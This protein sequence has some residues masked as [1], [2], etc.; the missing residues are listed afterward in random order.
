MKKISV[1][2]LLFILATGIFLVTNTRPVV[3]VSG[4]EWRPGNIIDDAIFTNKNAMSISQIQ[5]FLNRNLSTCDTNGTAPASDKGRPDL[6]HAQYAAQVGWPGPPYVCLNNYYE[7]PK[8]SPSPEQPANNFSGSI[9]P[10]SKSAAELIWN[11]S[12]TYNINPQVLLVKLHTES[13]GPLTLDKWPLYSQ[14][15]YAMG[16]HCPDSGPGGSANCDPNYSGFSIQILES[17]ALLRY[18]IN[19][20]S[21]PWWSYKKPL[22][23]NSIL[24]NIVESNC[25]ASNVYIQNYATAALYTY[26]PYQPNKPALDNLYGTGDGCS[27][28]GNR[29]FWRVFNDWFGT[30]NV[31]RYASPLYKTAN[32]D[33]IYAVVDG[34]KYPL[35]SFEIISALGLKSYPVAIVDNSMLSQYPTGATVSSTLAKKAYDPNGTIYLLDDGKRYPVSIESCRSYPDG[36][37]NSSTTWAL[38]CFNS[39]VVSSL[40]NQLIDY[41]SVEDIRLHSVILSNN[42]AWKVENGKKRRITDSIF[43][44]VLG[45]WGKV[46][47]MFQNSS[48][49]EGKL[50]IPT[51]SIVKFTG[52][53]TIYFKSEGELLRVNSMDEYR[54]WG[55]DK[56]PHLNISSAFNLPDPLPVGSSVSNII[57]SSNG[58]YYL[59]TI[60]KKRLVLGNSPTSWPVGTYTTGV[61]SYLSTFQLTYDT[62]L[63]RSSSGNIFTVESNKKRLIP[64]INELVGLGYTTNQINNISLSAENLVAY[65]GLKLKVHRLF[66][67]AGNNTIFYTNSTNSSLVVNSTNYPGLPY[68]D[69]IT[70]DA[71]TGD[72]YP[73]V[74]TYTP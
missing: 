59:S 21:Q 43:I 57:R 14:Y 32:S 40:P 49:P 36:A 30:T 52:D 11:A 5:E 27:A 4:A 42:A 6:T 31:G 69:I 7:V 66:K 55:M 70:V 34:K 29:N 8:T 15:K 10:G 18:Y 44:D 68:S 53:N 17:A 73:P 62:G 71:T 19:N 39:S 9:P 13:A 25:G 33:T 61:D 28:Y 56:L 48:Q 20:M 58:S 72:K 3:A 2:V 65:D 38:D 41:Y 26:T 1:L 16:A 45:G 67:V 22:R 63:Y 24:W 37:P 23:E 51:N 64:S 12:Q 47:W 74:G 35:A 54:S 60:D 46:R 50:L